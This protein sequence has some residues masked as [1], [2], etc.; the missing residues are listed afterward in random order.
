MPKE[1]EFST[2]CIIFLRSDRCLLL[3]SVPTVISKYLAVSIYFHK[4]APG[5]SR[6]ASV[7]T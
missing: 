4:K 1:L 5:E 3:L 2:Y 7:F 6:C